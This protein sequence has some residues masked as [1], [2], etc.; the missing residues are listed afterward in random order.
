MSLKDSWV[1][2]VNCNSTSNNAALGGSL[3]ISSSDCELTN[4]LFNGD[5]NTVSL[6]II[7]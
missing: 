4:C 5:Y 6:L 7:T 2:L 1:Q 3:Y